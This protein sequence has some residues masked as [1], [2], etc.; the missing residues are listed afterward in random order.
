M[1]QKEIFTREYIFTCWVKDTTCENVYDFF[2]STDMEERVNKICIGNIE[3]TEKELEHFH[4]Y[5]KFFNPIRLSTLIKKFGIPSTHIEKV[6]GTLKD[7]YNYCTKEGCYFT[8][9]SESELTIKTDENCVYTNLI[10]DIFDNHLSLY[11]CCKKYGKIA[12]LHFNNLEKLIQVRD[13]E[14]INSNITKIFD[15]ELDFIN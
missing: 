13:K 9:I 1:C 3:K 2:L 15:D 6:K 10:T 12:V 7:C 4:V 14:V 5:I 8:N 11:E